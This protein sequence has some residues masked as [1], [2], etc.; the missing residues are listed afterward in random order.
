MKA[1]TRS[2]FEEALTGLHRLEFH[3]PKGKKI[4]A[5]FHLTE[6]GLTSKRFIDCGGTAREEEAVSMQL[7]V[8]IDLH[9]RLRADKLLHILRQSRAALHLPDVP[10][11]IEY[12][13]T[14]I[15]RYR[16]GFDGERFH[17]LPMKTACLAK[18]Q[19]GIP[20]IKPKVKL[21]QQKRKQAACLPG[22]GC[23]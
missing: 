21:G 23:C 8:D 6:V 12:Q 13:D 17:L 3:L 9:H 16:L 4:P 20:S 1:L 22:T 14:S 15:S 7:Y 5:H 10:V 18:A 19:C 2:E 11:E